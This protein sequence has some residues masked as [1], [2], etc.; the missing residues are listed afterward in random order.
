M[1][2][3]NQKDLGEAAGLS[4]PLKSRLSL[5]EG[6]LRSLADGLRQLADKVTSEDILGQVLKRTLVADRLELVQMRVPIGVLL[7][8]FESRPDCLPQVK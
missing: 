6:K 3:A 2:A 1:L 8:I 5:S 4:A 7:V